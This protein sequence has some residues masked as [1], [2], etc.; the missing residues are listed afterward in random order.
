MKYNLQNVSLPRLNIGSIWWNG[1]LIISLSKLLHRNNRCSPLFFHI[2]DNI[3]STME[4]KEKLL[5]ESAEIF[6]D[7]NWTPI[8]A[9]IIGLFYVSDQKYFTFQEIIDTL[10]ISKSNAS[11][12]LKVLLSTGKVAYITKGD[13]KRKR[14]FYLSVGGSI[15]L[16]NNMLEGFKRQQMFFEKILSLRSDENPELNQLIQYQ[17]DYLEKIIPMLQIKTK[18]HF[19]E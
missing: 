10:N 15:T 7:I 18:E 17:K 9:K 6:K 3:Y 14:Y 8:A 5:I 19:T 16:I 12:A 11:R 2:K 13:N 4:D 1:R